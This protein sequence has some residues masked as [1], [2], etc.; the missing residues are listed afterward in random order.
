MF[1]LPQKM[2]FFEIRT[3]GDDSK[4][5]ARSSRAK[6]TA[7]SLVVYFYKADGT[8][9]MSPAPTD[10]TLKVG[11]GAESP[12]VALAPQ[13]KGGFSSGSGHFP[14]AFRGQLTAKINGESVETAFVVR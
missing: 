4:A 14:S 10:V 9:E 7:N 12:V 1:A 3:V 13:P 2:G 6:A 5:K 8:S 11:T